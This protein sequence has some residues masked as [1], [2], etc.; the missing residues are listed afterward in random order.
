VLAKAEEL[1]FY[2]V[3]HLDKALAGLNRIVLG[4]RA[5]PTTWKPAQTS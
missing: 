5:S 1:W 3:R 4:I 2:A